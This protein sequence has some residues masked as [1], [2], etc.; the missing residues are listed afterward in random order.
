MGWT[1]LTTSLD[2]TRMRRSIIILLENKRPL[3]L[4]Q[5]NK[6]LA[7]TKTMVDMYPQPVGMVYEPLAGSH[8]TGRDFLLIPLNRCFNHECN[9]YCCSE[10]TVMQLMGLFARQVLKPDSDLSGAPEIK[11]AS[12]LLIK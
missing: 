2:L 1:T 6:R 8:E 5:E 9:D 3:I 11:D 4:C 10:F 7:V 12:R